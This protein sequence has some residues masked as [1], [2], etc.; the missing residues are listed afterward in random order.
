[1]NEH[2]R[3]CCNSN[4]REACNR[5]LGLL[6]WHSETLCGEYVA[7]APQSLDTSAR[8]PLEIRVVRRFRVS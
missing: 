7:F 3:H 2:E 6:C 1:M 5:E 4:T 8:R